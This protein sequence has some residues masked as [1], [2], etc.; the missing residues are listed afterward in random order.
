MNGRN[1]GSFT[2]ASGSFNRIGPARAQAQR[3]R[4]MV[5]GGG[6]VLVALVILT[7]L[8]LTNKTDVDART[9]FQ[10]EPQ[11][12]TNIAFGTVVLVAPKVEVAKGTKLARVE[13]SKVYWPRDQVP[14]GAVREVENVRDMYAKR[15]LSANQPLIRSD[16]SATPSQI[17]IMSS[18]PPGHRAASIRVDATEGVEGWATPGAHVDVLLTYV[19]KESNTRTTRIVVEDAIVLSYDGST[20]AKRGELQ[21]TTSQISESST[22]TLMVSLEDSLELQTAKAIG[23]ISLVLRNISD[24]NAPIRKEFGEEDW[25]KTEKPRR[26]GKAIKGFVKM[27]GQDGKDKTLVLRE[28][29]S[30]WESEDSDDEFGE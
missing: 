1:S 2:R 6:S 22:V 13:L 5:V 11:A 21:A 14:E 10:V 30:W 12:T 19:K 9:D 18:L 4:L 26:K 23:K 17:G 27:S 24:S 15:N 3:E 20:Q 25:E 29:Q 8:L 7:T 28:D 16:L